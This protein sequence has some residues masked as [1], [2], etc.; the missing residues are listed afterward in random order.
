ML[1]KCILQQGFMLRKNPEMWKSWCVEAGMPS[2]GV[3]ASFTPIPASPAACPRLAL[4]GEEQGAPRP[5]PS[6]TCGSRVAAECSS[7]TQ[8]QAQHQEGQSDAW[9]LHLPPVS[10]PLTAQ[11]SLCPRASS[12]AQALHQESPLELRKE[13]K[14]SKRNTRCTK[15]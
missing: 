3:E 8:L 5:P 10:P 15:Q 13:V 7:D 9:L 2:P 12:G 4:A 1:E 14:G 11:L 6:P